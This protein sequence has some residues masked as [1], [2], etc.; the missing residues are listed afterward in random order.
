MPRLPFTSIVLG[1]ENSNASIA[2]D[3]VRSPT[4]ISPGAAVCSSLAATFTASPVTK[5]L[6]SRLRPTTTSPLLTP[7]RRTSWSPNSSC[8]LRR[9]ATP[10]RSARSASSSCAV[11]VPNAAMTASPT[12]FSTVP[13][14]ASTSALIAS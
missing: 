4:T 2:A 14:A 3:A 7:I 10:A 9:I 11:G 5:E 13:P 12:N 6:P 1:S 8:S